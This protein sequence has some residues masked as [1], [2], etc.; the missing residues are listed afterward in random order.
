MG[1][2]GR[3]FY[4]VV[5]SDSRRVPTG[6]VTET[7]G[8]YEPGKKPPKIQIDLGR[9]DELIQK[10]ASASATVRSLMER[11]RAASV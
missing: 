10:G 2:K 3:P 5:V 6:P 9:A 8:H 4:R 7:L 11:A 1:A